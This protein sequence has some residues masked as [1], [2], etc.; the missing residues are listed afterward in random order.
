MERTTVIRTR[1]HE[2]VEG[3]LAR[4][5][6]HEGMNEARVLRWLEQFPDDA[7]PLAAKMLGAIRYFTGLNLRAMTKDLFS[8][9]VDELTAAGHHRLAFAP[10]GEAGSGAG[11]VARV[12]RDLIRKTPHRLLSM[13][14]VSRLAPG[15]VDAIVF[16]DDFSGTGRTLQDW[17]GNVESLVRPTAVSVFVGLLV[18][19]EKARATIEE[20]AVVM[21]V[22][23]LDSAADVLGATSSVLSA[24]EKKR[25]VHFCKKTGCGD[26]FERGFGQCG[27][28]VAFKHGCPNNSLPILWWPSN[29]WRALFN[30]RAI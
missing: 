27:L 13:L 9:A 20:F 16:V 30:R 19:N 11:V 5:G 23:E 7:L 8:T 2:A 28:L 17:W 4:F 22:E 29:G 12:L 26:R 14:D 6:D 24:T 1:H 18:L 21:A 10:V 15:A 25:L 3:A